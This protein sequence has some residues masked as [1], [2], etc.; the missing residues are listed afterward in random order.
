MKPSSQPVSPLTPTERARRSLAWIINPVVDVLLRLGVTPNTVT[1]V[2]LLANIGVGVVAAS[3]NLTAAGF[4]LL[5]FGA[6]DGLDGALA[7]RMG[8]TGKFGAFLDSTLDR[9]SEAFVLFGLLIYAGDRGLVLEERLVYATLVGSLLVSYTRSRAETLGVE[10][11]V[12][13]LTRLERFLITSA[14]LILQQVTIGLILLATLTHVTAI[15]RIVHVWRSMR[16]K[17]D[18]SNR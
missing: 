15:Q 7:R 5:V 3:G 10:C 4:L 11:K 9:Y 13:L 8:V 16:S 1:V 17:Q 12:G 14:M 18:V 2:G 6:L